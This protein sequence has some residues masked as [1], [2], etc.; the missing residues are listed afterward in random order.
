MTPSQI[1]RKADFKSLVPYNGRVHRVDEQELR[2]RVIT[3]LHWRRYGMRGRDLEKK[4]KLT[5]S[6]ALE[7]AVT[8]GFD[9]EGLK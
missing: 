2:K 7:L 5:K 4:T 8:M 9:V 3:W 1:Q 6:K